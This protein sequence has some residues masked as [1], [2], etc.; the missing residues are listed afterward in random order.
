MAEA[1]GAEAYVIELEVRADALRSASKHFTK[2]YD[3]YN[4]ATITLSLV[5]G[6]LTLL[7]DG[8]LKSLILLLLNLTITLISTLQKYHDFPSRIRDAQKALSGIE[9]ATLALKNLGNKKLEPSDLGAYNRAII[10]FESAQTADERRLH[11]RESRHRHVQDNKN[12]GKWRRHISEERGIDLKDDTKNVFDKSTWKWVHV[13]KEGEKGEIVPS[14]IPTYVRFG[15]GGEWVYKVIEFPILATSEYFGLTPDLSK[16]RTLQMH[17]EDEHKEFY[18]RRVEGVYGIPLRKGD[19][20]EITRV[21]SES[22]KGRSE[23]RVRSLAPLSLVVG[24]YGS[25]HERP[26]LGVSSS[27]IAVSEEKSPTV[28]EDTTPESSDSGV[29][30]TKIGGVM[31]VFNRMRGQGRAVN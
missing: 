31:S 28:E 23:D 13:C 4:K 11:M 29:A 7:E 10:D 19:E 24:S 15:H 25:V 22:S 9:K 8:G 12:H 27:E 30:G 18:K 16:K 14:G 5:A 26:T 2:T 3:N 20:E 21:V 6:G 17:C 1:P